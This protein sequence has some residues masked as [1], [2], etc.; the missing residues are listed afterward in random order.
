M[1]VWIWNQNDKDTVRSD[2]NPTGPVS[3][4][5][6]PWG[7]RGGAA[8]RVKQEGAFGQSDQVACLLLDSAHTGKWPQ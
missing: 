5:S 4:F 3:I 7:R 2:Q 8:A 1:K 6:P